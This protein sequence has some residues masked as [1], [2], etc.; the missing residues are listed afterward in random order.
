MDGG[1]QGLQGRTSL[2]LA[3]SLACWG[4]VGGM[5]GPS[6]LG[7]GAGRGAGQ[8]CCEDSLF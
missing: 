1:A 8:Q 4:W 5:R 2:L 3:V 6:G 7:L